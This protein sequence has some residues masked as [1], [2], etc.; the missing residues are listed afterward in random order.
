MNVK[1]LNLPKINEAL[2][3]KELSHTMLAKIVTNNRN[4]HGNFVKRIENDSLTVK[5]LIGIMN[6]LDLQPNDAFV[7]EDL[8]DDASSISGLN[9]THSNN[10]VIVNNDTKVL[11]VQ[12]V[13][14]E[15]LLASKEET[16]N[17]LTQRIEELKRTYDNFVQSQLGQNRDENLS[18][19]AEKPSYQTFAGG[20][21]GAKSLRQPIISILPPQ[22]GKAVNRWKSAVYGLLVKTFANRNRFNSVGGCPQ[23]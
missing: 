2:K 9:V 13:M 14:L 11:R 22:Q 12:N 7:I 16:I 17:I 21:L 15:R 20:I 4:A 18:N 6:V 19:Y 8:V 3:R 5:S 10:N 23:T 1:S